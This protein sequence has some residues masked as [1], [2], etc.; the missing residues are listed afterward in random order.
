MKL[1]IVYAICGILTAMIAVLEKYH[2]GENEKN[3]EKIEKDK[4]I[5][6]LINIAQFYDKLPSLIQR[7]KDKY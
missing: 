6:K 7:K 2:K 3:N 5:K 4:K 1:I